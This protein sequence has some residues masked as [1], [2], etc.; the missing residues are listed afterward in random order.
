MG[1]SEQERAWPFE[2]ANI[3]QATAWDGEE[4]D[5]W[6]INADR[7]NAAQR[8]YDGVLVAAARVGAD[9]RVLDIGCGAG[10]ATREAARLAVRGEVVGVDLS[11]RMLEEAR[12]RSAAAGI[13][14]TTF[15]QA[16]AQ[17]HPLEAASFDVA[18]SRFGAMFFADPVAAFTNVGRALR[19][20]GRLALL[21][22]QELAHND[23][24]LVLR[25]ALAAGRRLPTPP[26][27]AP[28]PFGLADADGVRT[29]LTS[30]GFEGVDLRQLNEP[31]YFGSDVD[32]AY[33]FVA[34]L[35]LTRGL[36]DGLDEATRDLA[37]GRLRDALAVHATEDGVLV[38]AAAWLTTAHRP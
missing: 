7:Y 30:A 32:D 13:T 34:G 6:T 5:D 11:S 15:V 19:P 4:G 9:D 8:R 38:G 14:N 36:L 22:W 24:V 1:V 20:H 29:I 12:R 27:G 18:I 31:M 2:V 35:G 17:V 28:G 10:I 16:D 33:G 37:L 26:P 21:S 25:D 3:D 23:W